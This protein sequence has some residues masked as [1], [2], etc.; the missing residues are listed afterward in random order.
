MSKIHDA[1]LSKCTRCKK[2]FDSPTL[3]ANVCKECSI[4]LFGQDLL[5]MTPQPNTQERE[6]ANTALVLKWP[7]NPADLKGIKV[8]FR[9]SDGR[10]Y[11][12]DADGKFL[13]S[14]EPVWNA[15]KAYKQSVEIDAL[16][17]ELKAAKERDRWIPVGER[18][19]EKDAHVLFYEAR[20][21]DTHLGWYEA[22]ESVWRTYD[23]GNQIDDENVSHWRELPQPPTEKEE[24]PI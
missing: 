24:K 14:G 10:H 22:D 6:K 13:W 20:F 8:E 15:F 7:H 2:P 17:A 5:P 1:P 4:H 3:S 19:P 11:L 23:E 18:L 9:E 21:R 12:Y 16:R